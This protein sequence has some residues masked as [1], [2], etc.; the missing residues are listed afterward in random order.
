MKSTLIGVGILAGGALTAFLLIAL[1]PEPPKEAPPPQTPLVATTPLTV[2]QGSLVV[3]GTG[4]VRAAQAIDLTAEVAGRL[5]S[6]SEALNS[7]G[8]FRA[9]EVLARIDPSDYRA[10]VEQARARVTEAEFQMLQAREE[11]R[12]A[13]EEYD[14]LQRRTGRA[15]Q[16][17]S[18]DLGRLVYREPQLRR[19]EANLRSARAALQTAET[20]LERTAIRAPFNGRVETK[21]ADLGAYVAPGTPIASIYGT[22]AA[23]IVVPLPSRKA[24]LIEGLYRSRAER[25]TDI[26][27]TVSTEYGGETFAWDGYVDRVEGAIDR[28]TRTIDVVVRVPRP[29]D[30]DGMQ[31]TAQMPEQP[32]RVERPPLQVGRFATVDIEGQSRAEYAAIPRRAVR[33]REPNAPP[34]VWAVRGDSM[35]VEQR[36]RIIQTVGET[37][38][39]AP[40]PALAAGT[41]I[42]TSDLRVQTD[43]MRIRTTT[44]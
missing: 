27:A 7:G 13:R 22:D 5:V 18:T 35:L 10:A 31:V 17:D 33:V 25:R 38:Y 21:R 40:S 15:P 24:A 9:G 14:R 4:T 41:P 37:A 44:P 1:A 36:V 3:Q 28:Q 23:E 16:L 26:P 34:T 39:L 19:A 8:Q 43:S 11:V 29:Y 20:N 6:V 42:V 12:V 30:T 32:S 2:Q